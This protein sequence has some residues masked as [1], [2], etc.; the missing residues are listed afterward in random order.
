MS[1][2]I[3]AIPALN[4]G[5]TSE[6][7]VEDA[8]ARIVTAVKNDLAKRSGDCLPNRAI[9]LI[10]GIS[11]SG[12]STFAGRLANAIPGAAIV[13]VD[14][15]SWW[16][17]PVNWVAE[18]FAGVINPWLAGQDIDYRPPGWVAKNRPGSVIAKA[19]KRTNSEPS[20]LV[21]EGVGAA[22]SELAPY[23]SFIVWVNTDPQF[24]EDRRIERD[25]ATGVNGS[26][27]EQVVEFE[28]DWMSNE[29]PLH[30]QEKPWE[31]ANLI[32]EGVTP[33]GEINLRAF[34]Q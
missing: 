11:G 18:M 32:V 19:D 16:L 9:V 7:S 12:K 28:K 17:H 5:P 1:S 33:P 21:I 25:L 4:F 31:R 30:L 24:A 23:A 2:G 13:G 10:D 14:D 15:I 6:I 34:W 3:P 20:I 22:R 8:A 27:R 26:T 29:V